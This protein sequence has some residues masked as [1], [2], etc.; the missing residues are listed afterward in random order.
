MG[1]IMTTPDVPEIEKQKIEA[2]ALRDSRP[3]LPT[4]T[5]VQLLGRARS[6]QRH[7]VSM[8]AQHTWASLGA[9]VGPGILGAI[10][11]DIDPS[12][13][14]RLLAGIGDSTRR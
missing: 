10:T 6:I 2:K 3:D 5:Q 14:P 7:M 1:W 11:A 4:Q 8:F 12:M 9:T 13:V